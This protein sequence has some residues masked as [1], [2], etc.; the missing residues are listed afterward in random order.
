M[1][2]ALGFWLC[3]FAPSIIAWYRVRNGMPIALPLRQLVIVNL[4]IAWTVVGWFL[5]LANALG[6]NPVASVAPKLAKFLQES[7]L[8]GA[9]PP[10]RPQQGQA[11]GATNQATCS[12][13]G[14]T[15]SVTCSQCQGRGSWYEPPQTATGSAELKHCGYCTSSGRIRCPNCSGSGHLMI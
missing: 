11:S 6:Y 15:G 5:L 9:A 4:L 10:P 1:F 7:G 14:G 8:G 12:Q 3:Y 2:S 13:C